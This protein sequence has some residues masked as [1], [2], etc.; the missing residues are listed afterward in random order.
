MEQLIIML[1]KAIYKAFSNLQTGPDE[2]DDGAENRAGAR[3]PAR[4]PT[5][6]NQ[7]L[8]PKTVKVTSWEEELK[9]LLEGDKPIVSST[10]PQPGPTAVV[11]AKPMAPPPIPPIVRPKTRPVMVMPSLVKSKAV[12]APKPGPTPIPVP[13]VTTFA[14]RN[15]APMRESR[16]A[17]ARAGQLDKTM[18][19][20]IDKVPTQRVQPTYVE[21][22]PLSPDVAQV[23][24]LFKNPRTARQ[25]VIA[26]VIL[27]PP[28]GLEPM[29][30]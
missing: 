10:R 18:S 9:R 30:T 16:Q 4:P 11:T 6:Q 5:R 8:P 24:S 3:S 17:Y 7:P 12:R 19:A 27:G 29:A 28:R 25:A 1:V 20:Q 14:T 13:A 26:S 2:S 21:R 15:M 23:I 22:A